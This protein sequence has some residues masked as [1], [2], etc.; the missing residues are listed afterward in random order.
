MDYPCKIIH[1]KGYTKWR[2]CCLGSGAGAGTVSA[3]GSCFFFCLS[4][5]L[6]GAMREHDGFL[7]GYAKGEMRRVISA[8]WDKWATCVFQLT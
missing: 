2:A 7:N 5:G 4:R 6:H 8:K 1:L 3:W